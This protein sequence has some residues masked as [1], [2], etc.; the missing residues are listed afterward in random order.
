MET[1]IRILVAT[2]MSGI[3]STAWTAPAALGTRLG[4]ARNAAG[5]GKIAY[6]YSPDGSAGSTDVWVMNGDGSDAHAITDEPGLDGFPAWGPDGRHLVI[7]SERQ[8]P[9]GYDHLYVLKDDGSSLHPLTA[10]PEAIDL[11]PAWS[12]VGRLIAFARDRVPPDL[13]DFDIYVIRTDG[14]GLHRVATGGLFAKQPTWSPDGH[15]IAFASDLQSGGWAIFAV[16][17]DGSDLH[18]ISDRLAVAWDPAWSPDGQ[19][20][21]LACST[22]TNS[23]PEICEMNPDGS[24]LQIITSGTDRWVQADQPTWSPDGGRIVF[25]RWR[26]DGEQDLWRVRADGSRVQRLTAGDGAEMW[27]AYASGRLARALEPPAPGVRSDGGRGARSP[28]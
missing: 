11:D 5:I 14:T 15:W 26:N 23:A 24:D 28:R 22:S 13:V 16:R 7:A 25:H 6:G 17:P 18:R 3:V 12:P 1:R 10:D 2:M 20:I 9:N 8:D 21:A 27:P 4:S 19:T